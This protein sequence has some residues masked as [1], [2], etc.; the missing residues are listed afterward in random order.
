M[1]CKGNENMCNLVL[2]SE[3]Y[4][5]VESCRRLLSF[6]QMFNVR[7]LNFAPRE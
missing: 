6:A 1:R 3:A 4:R 5:A 7:V 2:T